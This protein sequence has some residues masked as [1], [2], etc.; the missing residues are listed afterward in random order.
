VLDGQKLTH[1]IQKYIDLDS[2]NVL[3]YLK[4]TWDIEIFGERIKQ[5]K[6]NLIQKVM[7]EDN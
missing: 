7:F 5:N 2:L 4:N 1:N 6:M 3:E